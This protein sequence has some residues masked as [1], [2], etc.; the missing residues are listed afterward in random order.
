MVRDPVRLMLEH[1]LQQGEPV[2]PR[3]DA[4]TESL[5]IVVD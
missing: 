2:S 4:V 5:E 3:H 1:E